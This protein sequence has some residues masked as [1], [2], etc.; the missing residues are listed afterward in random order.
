MAQQGPRSA[1]GGIPDGVLI[2]VLV[3]LV[4]A[5]AATWLSTGLA[6][7]VSH[8]EWPAGVRFSRSGT[9]IRELAAD[10]GDVAAAWPESPPEALPPA[11]TFW[12]VFGGMAAFVLALA[13]LA[14]W[15]WL[16]VTLRQAERRHAG[17]AP[18]PPAKSL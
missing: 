16:R 18:E 14:L 10:P 8:Q 17:E 6:G 11:S 12:W 4:G 13:F 15:A 2:G 9:A 5:T 3:L 1:Q 7:L